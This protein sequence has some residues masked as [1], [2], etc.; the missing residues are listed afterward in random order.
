MIIIVII[1]FVIIYINRP[2]G[3]EKGKSHPRNR[4]IRKCTDYYIY[5]YIYIYIY[6]YIIDK[7]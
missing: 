2:C 3:T 1:K 5:I 4:C 7:S 6:V